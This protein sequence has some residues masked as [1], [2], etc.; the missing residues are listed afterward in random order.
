MS[1]SSKNKVIIYSYRK[2]WKV[3]KKLYSFGNLRLPFP[4]DPMD[5]AAYGLGV[6]FMLAVGELIPPFQQVS[7]LI[8]Y[9]VFPYLLT[10]AFFKIKPDG[11]NLFKYLAGCLRYALTV[12]GTFTQTFQKHPCKKGT[13]RISWQC[14]QGFPQE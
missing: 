1:D 7:W 3:D 4:I 5:L 2:V 9:I 8:R 12:R 6:L 14:S 11:K 10:K 13:V